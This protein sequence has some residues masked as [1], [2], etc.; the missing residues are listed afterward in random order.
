MSPSHE[1]LSWIL[2]HPDKLLLVQLRFAVKTVSHQTARFNRAVIQTADIERDR[3]RGSVQPIMADKQRSLIGA[4]D[5]HLI[6]MLC[7][8]G[9]LRHLWG[10]RSEERRV[11]RGSSSW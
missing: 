11:G 9:A 7:T 10:Q 2:I 3:P 8:N 6:T 1:S 4:I 5:H